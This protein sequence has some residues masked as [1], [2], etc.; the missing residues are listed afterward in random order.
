MPWAS[1][2]TLLERVTEAAT[3]LLERHEVRSTDAGGTTASL[4]LGRRAADG[5]FAL[6]YAL[7]GRL[8]TTFPV[9]SAAEI[10]AEWD[11]QPARPR[12]NAVVPR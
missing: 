10:L 2:H 5:P 8:V 1:P 11:E 3:D 4:A 12:W 7:G 9:A 6:A